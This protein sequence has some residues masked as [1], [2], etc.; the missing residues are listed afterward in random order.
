MPA[1]IVAPYELDG[2]LARD[3]LL[4]LLR[5][6]LLRSLP[7]LALQPRQA[8]RGLELVAT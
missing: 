8:L 1:R 2:V 5:L 7:L 4:L 6:L 3:I